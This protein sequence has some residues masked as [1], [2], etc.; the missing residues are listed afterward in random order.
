MG[1]LALKWLLT[2]PTLVSVQPNIL[3]VKELEEFAAACD[4][5]KLTSGLEMAEIQELVES[6]FGFG[7]EGARV[8]FKEQRRCE[9]PY[10][11]S[12]SARARRACVGVK[13]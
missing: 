6:D 13:N 4:G 11:E 1:Q 3:T 7:P 10:A 12:L 9:R 5:D 8:R 2:W